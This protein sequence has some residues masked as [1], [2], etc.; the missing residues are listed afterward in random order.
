MR[1]SSAASSRFCRSRMAAAGSVCQDPERFAA[2][3]AYP[4]ISTAAAKQAAMAGQY[5]SSR[6]LNRTLTEADLSLGELVYLPAGEHSL[7][8]P[9][10]RF[11]VPEPR[12]ADQ[13]A[14]LDCVSVLVPAV[15]PAYLT[16]FPT[17]KEDPTE[18]EDARI[19][20]LL[21]GQTL[22]L[23]SYGGSSLWAFTILLFIFLRLDMEKCQC[24]CRPA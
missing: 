14:F 15:E 18:A 17:V 6:G 4:I 16:D 1:I 22:P 9:F 24:N 20:G 10:Y 7:L 13:E 11:W 5:Y 21:T 3:D 19:R 2:L 12:I 8:L 23:I